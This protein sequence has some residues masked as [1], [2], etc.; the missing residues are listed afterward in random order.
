MIA[1]R[2]EDLKAIWANVVTWLIWDDINNQIFIGLW[3]DL[4]SQMS[5]RV[6]CLYIWYFLTCTKMVTLSWHQLERGV[7]RVKERHWWPGQNWTDMT[8]PAL[9]KKPVWNPTRTFS[10]LLSGHCW[11][12]R[13]TGGRWRWKTERFLTRT[14]FQGRIFNT[15]RVV[16]EFLKSLHSFAV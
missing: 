7:D 3:S 5:S 15:K 4:S 6:C 12:S 1:G 10:L 14:T 13:G 16:G 2:R 9:S 11:A 8:W